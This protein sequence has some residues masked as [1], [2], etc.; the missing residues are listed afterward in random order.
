M[1]NRRSRGRDFKSR[2]RIVEL[3]YVIRFRPEYLDRVL[4][5]SKR[6]TV[7]LGI[8]RPRFGEVLIT[9]GN[10][11]YGVGEIE[12]FEI[13]RIDQ[14]PENIVREEGFKSK[15]ELLNALRQLYPEIKDTSFVT[16]IRFKV[17]KIFKN[18]KPLNMAVQQFKEGK[19]SID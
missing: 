14:L 12:S 19:L 3:N 6:V 17:K 11:V 16:V 1:M 15:S 13:Y 9:C 8:V 18:P 2:D 4:S 10:L 7:R 5:G